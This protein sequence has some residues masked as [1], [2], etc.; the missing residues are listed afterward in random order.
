MPDSNSSNCS[1][2]IELYADGSFCH[3]V[4][5]GAWAFKVPELGLEQV[6]SSRGSTVRR[7]E[8]LA[9]LNGLEQI[10]AVDGSE[11]PIHLFSDC[12]STVALISCLRDG[13]EPKKPRRYDDR[14]D[15]IPRLHSVLTRRQI[16]VTRYVGGSLH[17]Q[18]C[19][20][21]ASRRLR[22]EVDCNP[23]L[24]HQAA[25]VRQRS[26]LDNLVKERE[27]LLD[28]LSRLDEEISLLQLQVDTLQS[29]I[30]TLGIPAATGPNAIQEASIELKSD[31]T[32]TTGYGTC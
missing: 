14:A 12:E 21:S 25:L 3:E 16:H 2:C 15:L 30:R 8:F 4:G 11:Q 9:A 32:A 31:V 18:A 26:R 5:I 7:F 24:H 13:K 20:L 27:P 17:H 28:K 10:L 29:A 1:V 19:H 6:G 23:V 22:Q